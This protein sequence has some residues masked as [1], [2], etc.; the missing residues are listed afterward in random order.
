MNNNVKRL[1]ALLAALMMSSS[2]AAVASAA[3]TAFIKTGKKTETA[4]TEAAATVTDATTENKLGNVLKTSGWVKTDATVLDGAAE[5]PLVKPAAQKPVKHIYKNEKPF[6]VTGK[7][8]SKADAEKELKAYFDA[9]TYELFMNEGDARLFCEGAYFVSSDE[10]VV[11]YDYQSGRLV[12]NDNGNASV[13]VYTKGGVPFFRLDV[14]VLHTLGSGYSVVDLVPEDWRL[15]GAGDTTTFTVSSERYDEDEFNFSIVHGKD[16][17]S[18]TK[19]GKLTVTGNGPIVVRASL[20]GNANVYGEALL[21][22][23]EY[24]SSFYDGYYTHSTVKPH[25]HNNKLCYNSCD[26][27]TTWYW[28][29]DY[30][31]CDIRDCYVSGWIKSYDGILIPVLKK[32]SATVVDSD[33]TERDTTV[34]RYDNVDIG[35]LLREAYG[36]KDALYQVIKDYNLFKKN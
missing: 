17:A 16:I 19:A 12:A 26:E 8:Y 33:G 18:I 2:F 36:D 35:E 3:D 22:A 31:I 14:K 28:G 29:H 30:D 20:K 25:K 5:N 10:S 21:Y 15:D 27:Y 4:V 13:Y 24:V 11:Y 6:V 23:G 1:S 9:H 7:Y 34:I 32:T